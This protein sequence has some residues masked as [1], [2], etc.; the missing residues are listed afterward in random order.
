[1][2]TGMPGA[3]VECAL[4][5]AFGDPPRPDMVLTG[6]LLEEVPDVVLCS[7]VMLG[8]R[9]MLPLVLLLPSDVLVLCR[10][11]VELPRL[12]KSTVSALPLE[13]CARAMPL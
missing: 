7:L 12:R 10:G 9:E 8:Y 5:L 6:E 13:K 4:L 2:V 3:P 11:F 1:M